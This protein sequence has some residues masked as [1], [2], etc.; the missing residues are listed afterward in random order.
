[1][2]G[3][4]VPSSTRTERSAPQHLQQDRSST[5]GSARAAGEVE[6]RGCGGS[7]QGSHRLHQGTCVA[8]FQVLSH[9]MCSQSTVRLRSVLRAPS[10]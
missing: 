3:V 10:H 9:T 1:M 2:S 5:E 8:R 7:A 6:P 4:T